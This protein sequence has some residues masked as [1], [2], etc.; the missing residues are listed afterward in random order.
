V[1]PRTLAKNKPFPGHSP[2]DKLPDQFMPSLVIV[3]RLSARSGADGG[4]AAWRRG[5]DH[6]SKVGFC[7]D[8]D[9][10]LFNEAPGI[11]Q[12]PHGKKGW[13]QDRFLRVEAGRPGPALG[14]AVV[15]EAQVY[16]ILMRGDID[17]TGL[18]IS[19]TLGPDAY[20][21]Y[22]EFIEPRALNNDAGAQGWSGDVEFRM[23]SPVF[24]FPPARGS[25]DPWSTGRAGVGKLRTIK[26]L[27]LD[28]LEVVAL[29]RHAAGRDPQAHPFEPGERGDRLKLI[30]PR[31]PLSRSLGRLFSGFSSVAR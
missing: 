20:Q 25:S 21:A 29:G 6:V 15:A 28:A 31:G 2:A 19:L 23:P 3:A 17:L 9:G 1:L 30:A 12:T 8:D 11:A 24:A 16:D 5:Y 27:R 7:A 10:V 26:R 13:L 4:G 18:S 22:R 14:T